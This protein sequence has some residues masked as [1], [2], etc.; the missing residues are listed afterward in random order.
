MGRYQ[1]PE[2]LGGLVYEAAED[3][4]Q[5]ADVGFHVPGL[6]KCVWLPRADLVEIL[7]PWPPLWSVVRVGDTQILQHR[8]FERDPTGGRWFRCGSTHAFTWEQVCEH[9]EPETI[10]TPPTEQTKVED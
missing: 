10:W 2:S 5:Y 6:S 9:G 8:P 4:R 1:L 7:P 3:L